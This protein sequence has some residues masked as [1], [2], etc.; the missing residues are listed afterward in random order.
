[1]KIGVLWLFLAVTVSSLEYILPQSKLKCFHIE[2][3]G[4][5]SGNF[6]TV[7]YKIPLSNKNVRVEVRD[8]KNYTINK[9]S[10]QINIQMG[11]SH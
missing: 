10:N 2:P 4:T 5:S 9:Q 1:M 8:A 7:S 3:E 6:F 11:E